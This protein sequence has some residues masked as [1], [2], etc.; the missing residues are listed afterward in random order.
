MR[1]LLRRSELRSFEEDDRLHHGLPPQQAIGAAGDA[2]FLVGR[3]GADL[4]SLL[5]VL[6]PN[7]TYDII[8]DGHWS[9]HQM[10][11]YLLNITGPATL[12]LT[13]WGL[14]A[15]PLQSILDMVRSGQITHLNM[16]LDIRVKLQSAQAYQVLRTMAEEANVN[17][18]LTKIHAKI[19]VIHN[20]DHEIRVL[21]SANLTNNPRIES[22]NISTHPSLAIQNR[23]WIDLIMQG[24][25]PFEA[26]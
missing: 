16:L 22:Y 1:T 19:N 12:W 13:S 14:T 17:T 8:T 26:E 23:T 20:A 21:T 9:L 10:L 4:K 5:P 25:Q 11:A 6:L 18:W 2:T 24:A 7:H 3:R 15:E